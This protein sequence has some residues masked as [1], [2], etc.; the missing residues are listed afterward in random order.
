MSHELRTPLARIVGL[1]ELASLEAARLERSPAM[2]AERL[3]T[4]HTQIHGSAQHLDRLIRDV[5]D[6]ARQQVGQLRVEMQPLDLRSLLVEVSVMGAPMAAERQLAWR[7]ELPDGPLPVLGDR[8]RLLQVLLNLLANAVKFT[9]HGEVTLRGRQQGGWITI[10]VSDT[11]IGVPPADQ[12]AVFDEFHQAPSGPRADS[13]AWG[14]DWRSRAGWSSCTAAR[15][16]CAHR[17][18]RDGIH[19]LL[20]L[21]VAMPAEASS[22]APVAAR[23]PSTGPALVISR[24]PDSGR[25]LWQQLTADGFEVVLAEMQPD[26]HLL[27]TVRQHEPGAVIIECAPEVEWGWEVLR[28]L[29]EDPLTRDVPVI[30]YSLVEQCGCGEVLTFDVLTK[31]VGAAQLE[32]LLARYAQ[33]QGSPTILIV[34]D[35]EETVRI[36]ELLVQERLPQSAVLTATG[37][38][39]ALTILRTQIP[40]LV[41]LD[42]LMPEV[43]GFNVLAEFRADPRTRHVPVVVLTGQALSELDMERLARGVALVLSKGVLTTQETVA[44]ISDILAHAPRLGTE[45]QRQMRRAM[46]YIRTHYAEPIT[47]RDIAAYL[48]LHE[49]SLS[50]YFTQEVGV[51]VVAY[52]NRFRVQQACKLLASSQQ[53]IVE[54]ALDVGFGSHSYFTRLCRRDRHDTDGLSQTAQGGAKV[55]RNS[56]ETCKTDQG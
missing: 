6:L 11:G 54:I 47:R 55:Y 32:P 35:D 26:D 46:A 25:A 24:Q 37:G 30:F 52:L 43:D 39:A 31:P 33:P 50:H 34:D 19:L 15:L 48:G 56:A 12:A 2:L 13:A 38:R 21:P 22:S 28:A 7:S 49:D 42:L 23:A 14:W 27:R 36:N 3:L 53:S 18:W 40:D 5:L 29:K 44:R 41:L 4:H 1:T 8:A 20:A 17:A 51:P 9:L 45:G 16:V 10:E